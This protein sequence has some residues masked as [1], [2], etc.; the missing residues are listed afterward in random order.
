MVGV[1][2][3]YAFA[4]P[5]MPGV[6]KF[7]ATERDPTDVLRDANAEDTWRPPDAYVVAAA[8]KVDDPLSVVRGIHTILASRRVN[9]RLEF[10]RFEADEARALLELV[11]GAAASSSARAL[12]G[13]MSASHRTPYPRG[14]LSYME[15]SSA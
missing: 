6:I 4:T 15:R 14:L 1:G 12:V 2:W 7:G 10:F 11:P 9:P 5:S 13:R 8:K 3:V